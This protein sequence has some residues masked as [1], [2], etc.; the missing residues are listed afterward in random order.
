VHRLF[1]IDKF[2]QSYILSDMFQANPGQFCSQ[3]VKGY[4]DSL[5]S[6]MYF[7]RSVAQVSI[8]SAFYVNLFCMKVFSAAF[9]WLS[10]GFGKSTKALSY[11]KRACK[12]LTK[13]TTGVNFTNTIQA[14]FS[15]KSYFCSFC[16]LTIF[17]NYFVRKES[18][19]MLL[20]N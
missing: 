16:V 15:H 14:P 11:K 6:E 9:L 17:L 1:L 3:E 20:V 7:F 8:S 4:F 10:F 18:S 5:F 13:L 2:H 12:I 19:Q